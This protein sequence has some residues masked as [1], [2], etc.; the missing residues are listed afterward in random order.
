[1]AAALSLQQ[2]SQS[3]SSLEPF[4]RA[5]LNS[6]SL[7]NSSRTAT[8]GH[9]ALP[10]N[11]PPPSLNSGDLNHAVERLDELARLLQRELQFSVDETSGRV[12]IKVIDKESNELI[13]QIPP[14][15]I[16]DLISRFEQLNS[17]LVSAE[18]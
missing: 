16:L 5:R 13:R 14:E 18:A 6:N 12:I 11:G 10:S 4:T 17:G 3:L 1:M 8:A 9:T 15:E 2:F 7:Q